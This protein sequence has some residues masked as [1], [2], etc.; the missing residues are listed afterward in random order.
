MRGALALGGPGGLDA[1]AGLGGPGVLAL[2]R[3]VRDGPGVLVLGGL[4][5]AALGAGLLPG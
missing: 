2:G 3:P 4:G 5:A 1:A